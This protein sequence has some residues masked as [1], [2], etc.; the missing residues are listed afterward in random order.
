MG[1]KTMTELKCIG[2]AKLREDENDAECAHCGRAIRNLA[3]MN[4]GQVWGRRCAQMSVGSKAVKS[5]RQVR[6]VAECCNFPGLNSLVSY[7]GAIVETAWRS[8]GQLVKGQRFMPM[9]LTVNGTE[10]AGAIKQIW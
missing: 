2:T 8:V 3:F 1:M 4:N 5:A 7:N 6:T 10:V 9:V